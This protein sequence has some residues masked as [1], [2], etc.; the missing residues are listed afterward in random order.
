MSDSTL[1]LPFE[2]LNLR[3]NPFGERELS[4]RRSLAILHEELSDLPDL[5]DPGFA[6]LILGDKGRGKTSHLLGLSAQHPDSVYLYI[7]E[8]GLRQLPSELGPSPLFI[9]EAQRL[10]RLQRRRLFDPTRSLVIGSHED[11]E[12]QLSKAGFRV[13]SRMASQ[14]LDDSRLLAIF[15]RRIESVRRTD[16]DVPRLSL[17]ACQR[18]LHHFGDDVRAMEGYLYDVFQQLQG[19][20]DVKLQDMD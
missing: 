1:S 12:R 9:D 18:L 13:L 7:P 2:H 19:P 6:L 15:T 10:T 17:E 20:C 11:H 4:E 14:G 3:R 16:D 5:R 8:E